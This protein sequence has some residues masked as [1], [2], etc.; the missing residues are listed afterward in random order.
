MVISLALIAWKYFFNP[1]TNE[2]FNSSVLM[3]IDCSII[4]N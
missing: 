1:S 4:E 3:V 2:G